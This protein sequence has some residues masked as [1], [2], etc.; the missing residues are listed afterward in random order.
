LSYDLLG[1]SFDYICGNELA[2]KEKK[3]AGD[4]SAMTLMKKATLPEKGTR[5]DMGKAKANNT[6]S[7]VIT[8][9][10]P[11]AFRVSGY[12][13]EVRVTC[14]AVMQRRISFVKCDGKN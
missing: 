3:I 9:I 12:E 7:S 6:P 1:E 8:L 13:E 2:R 14:F 11:P 5:K 10:A 4:D